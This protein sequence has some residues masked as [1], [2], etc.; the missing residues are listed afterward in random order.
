MTGSEPGKHFC[1]NRFHLMFLPAIGIASARGQS[2]SVD[3]RSLDLVTD[4]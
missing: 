3:E 1:L 4:K 2:E